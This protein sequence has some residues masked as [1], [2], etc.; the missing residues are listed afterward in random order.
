MGVIDRISRRALALLIGF[1][2]SSMIQPAGA[3]EPTPV[4]VGTGSCSAT[5]CHKG[6]REP[7][8]LKGSEY[9]FSEAYDPHTRAYQVLY[10][11]RS[12]VIFKNLKDV[13]N[14]KNIEAPIPRPITNDLCLRCHVYQG[15]DSKA[16]RTR[17]E[18]FAVE[19]GVGCEGCHGAAEKWL[20]PHTQG[21]WKGLTE[22][23]KQVGYGL[24]PTKNL[25]A[26]G[27]RCAE[28]HVGNAKA[29]VNHDLVA[30]GHPRLNFEYGGQLAKLPKHWRI[31]DDKG[32]NPDYEAKVWALGQV[33]A[34]K[35]SLDLLASRADRA[36]RAQGETPW[37]EFS[38]YSC[39][40]CH[41]PV[42][43][44]GWRQADIA[45][46]SRPGV[47][48]W[49]TWYFPMVRAIDLPDLDTHSIESGFGEIRKEMTRPYP[50]PELV[51]RRAR[52]A[53]AQLDQLTRAIH[54]RRIST[55]EARSM[56]RIAL[57]DGD[58]G[59]PVDWDQAAQK[60]LAIV[61]LDKALAES[62]RAYSGL[63]ARA[64]LGDLYSK[65]N[66]PKVVSTPPSRDGMPED[67]RPRPGTFD[68]PYDYT[69]RMIADDLK[70]LQAALPQP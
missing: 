14:V 3:D 13:E 48:P 28:C 19:D 40:S 47:L 65:L 1:A 67:G 66:L 10:D 12:K 60:Y 11:D 8:D 44:S 35:A 22:N 30:A 61:A 7:L 16:P 41:H 49:G 4:W 59:R 25:L 2:C 70:R 18:G 69:P 58:N 55:G 32:R 34:A 21:W 17:A 54:D 36:S 51:A 27:T 63:P 15:F 56:M 9:E 5:S 29:E 45:P 50:E 68:S 39:F 52:A 26:R 53:S 23:Q 57:T 31:N 6:R 42:T 43:E 62:D 24:Y 33:L 46:S 37:P 64:I 20:V 38:E